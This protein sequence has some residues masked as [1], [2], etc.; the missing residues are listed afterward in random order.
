MEINPPVIVRK[1]VARNDSEERKF[2]P[3]LLVASRKE[4]KVAKLEIVSLFLCEK[5]PLNIGNYELYLKRRFSFYSLLLVASRNELNVGKLE[6][7]SLHIC[8]KIPR[9]IKAIILF[10]LWHS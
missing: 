6:I 7:D 1:R 4:I 10:F 3:R 9:N 5:I 2:S 8:E